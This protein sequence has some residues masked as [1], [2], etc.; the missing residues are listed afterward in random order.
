MIEVRDLHKAF[1]TVKAV[2]GVSF[3]AAD[4]Q[5]TGLLGPNGAGKTTSLRM[6]YTLMKPDRGQ[7]LVDGIDATVDAEGVSTACKESE[8]ADRWGLGEMRVP[9]PNTAVDRD[10]A[11]VLGDGQGASSRAWRGVDADQSSHRCPV[12]GAIVQVVGTGAGLV[13][14]VATV[15]DVIREHDRVDAR[16]CSVEHLQFDLIPTVVSFDVRA[17]PLDKCVLSTAGAWVHPPVHAVLDLIQSLSRPAW[18][19]TDEVRVERLERE[20]PQHVQR[21]LDREPS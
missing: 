14:V 15:A 1:G 6:L 12:G 13:N 2:D 3:K 16:A 10:L 17:D 21:I 20:C 7:V 5:I 4:G 18:L 19:R 11:A 8:R 9:S